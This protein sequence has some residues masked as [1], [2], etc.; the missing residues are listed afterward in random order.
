MSRTETRKDVNRVDEERKDWTLSNG[1]NISTAISDI[2]C[3]RDI[4][5]VAKAPIIA[6]SARQPTIPPNHANC[7]QT[8]Q[9]QASQWTYP[10]LDIFP[11]DMYVHTPQ[12][13][14][15][16]HRTFVSRKP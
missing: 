9:L 10:F 11:W 7:N 8:L 1:R 12:T 4:R 5:T 3:L 16:V 2:S 6:K 14:D 15:Q 13:G